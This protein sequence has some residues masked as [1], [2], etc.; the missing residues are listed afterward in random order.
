[1]IHGD[2]NAK[3][4]G[5]EALC[6]SRLVNEGDGVDEKRHVVREGTVGSAPGTIAGFQQCYFFAGP[7]KPHPT[8]QP[9]SSGSDNYD[10]C[11]CHRH[12]SIY[13]LHAKKF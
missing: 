3:E 8:H 2:N 6:R 11:F 5:Q 10:I 13:N 1:M 9:G 12:S 4:D 7:R